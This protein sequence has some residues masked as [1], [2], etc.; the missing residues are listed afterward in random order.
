MPHP[1]AIE[2]RPVRPGTLAVRPDTTNRGE[3]RWAIVS[4]DPLHH[5]NGL[6]GYKRGYGESHAGLYA[7]PFLTQEVA[8]SVAL[9][10]MRR[11]YHVGSFV[12]T[13]EGAP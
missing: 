11:S 7:Y 3:P 8:T 4:R 5:S 13:S 10:I 6:R 9:D 2:S 1:I 12:W